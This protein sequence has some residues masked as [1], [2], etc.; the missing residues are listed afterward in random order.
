MHAFTLVELMVTLAVVAILASIAG[1]SFQNLMATMKTRSASTELMAALVQARSLAVQRNGRA[2]VQQ[3]SGG[4]QKGW[5]VYFDADNSGSYGGNDELVGDQNEMSGITITGAPAAMTYTRSG[6]LL[7]NI[8][9]PVSITIKPT[10][11][12]GV[13]RCISADASGRPYLRKEACS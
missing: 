4:W 11:V 3:K 10:A 9:L 5:Q 6:R 13:A 8:S 7:G 1:P 12:T 2:V